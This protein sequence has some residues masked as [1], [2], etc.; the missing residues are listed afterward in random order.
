MDPLFHGFELG[1]RVVSERLRRSPGATGSGL[2]RDTPLASPMGR[3]RPERVGQVAVD[4]LS[5]HCVNWGEHSDWDT[6]RAG[7]WRMHRCGFGHFFIQLSS[8]FGLVSELLR[9]YPL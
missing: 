8:V 3:R 4:T 7:S 1:V 5:F 2:R 6:G 9:P